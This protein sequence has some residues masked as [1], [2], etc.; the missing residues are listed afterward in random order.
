MSYDLY[1][2]APGEVDCPL[3]IPKD[4]A[5]LCA[6]SPETA[7]INITYNFV[8][9]FRRTMGEEGV[10]AIYGL[11]GEQSIP[12]L[13]S[14]IDQLKDDEVEHPDTWKPTE[15]RAKKVLRRLL[16]LAQLQPT[17]IWAGD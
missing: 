17:G 13:Q 5:R 1:L 3:P 14:A 8:W 12:I 2:H 4:K 16:M 15:G 10:R 11:T 7:E 9:I 6:S